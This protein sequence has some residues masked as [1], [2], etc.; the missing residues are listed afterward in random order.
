[1]DAKRKFWAVELRRFGLRLAALLVLLALAHIVANIIRLSPIDWLR[2]IAGGIDVSNAVDH[3]FKYVTDT[4][5]LMFICSSN[6]IICVRY[7]RCYET[8]E[9][10]ICRI[11]DIIAVIFAPIIVHLIL[12]PRFVSMDYHFISLPFLLVVCSLSWKK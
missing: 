6:A 7:L 2:M 11:M 1:M 5:S 4:D 3:A 10:V 12:S 9:K 8:Q